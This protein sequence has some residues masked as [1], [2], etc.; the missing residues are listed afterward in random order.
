[1]ESGIVFFF[2][3]QV[4]I[5]KTIL[6]SQVTLLFLLGKSGNAESRVPNMALAVERNVKPQ[7]F[8]VLI[9]ANHHTNLT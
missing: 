8:D 5:H 6:K 2:F 9:S 7:F 4:E 3:A 1:M